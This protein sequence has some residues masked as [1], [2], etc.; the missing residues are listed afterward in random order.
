MKTEA[1]KRATHIIQREIPEYIAN[2][3]GLIE[4]GKIDKSSP[5]W[6][7]HLK[8]GAYVKENVKL[9]YQPSHGD[10][11][12]P[13]HETPTIVIRGVDELSLNESKNRADE[14][15]EVPGMQWKGR[16]V[17]NDMCDRLMDLL[18]E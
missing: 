14:G 8:E 16:L 17:S 12:K 10:E 13:A 1:R 6:R 7:G 11:A 15:S 3:N 18:E 2:L 4:A 9:V 5:L